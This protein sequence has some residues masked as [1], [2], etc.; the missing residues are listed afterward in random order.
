MTNLCGKGVISQGR[1]I[2]CPTSVRFRLPHPMPPLSA[3]ETNRAR[4]MRSPWSSSV[5][6]PNKSRLGH[7]IAAPMPAEIGVLPGRTTAP[8]RPSQVRKLNSGS[9]PREA[10]DIQPWPT[11]AADL[12]KGNRHPGG[13]G[14]LGV[15]GRGATRMC[16]WTVGRTRLMAHE[17]QPHAHPEIGAGN[18]AAHM[19][20]T[21]GGKVYAAPEHSGLLRA[22]RVGGLVGV[23]DR[24]C[25]H[26]R[27]PQRAYPADDRKPACTNRLPATM[28]AVF[29][30]G[31]SVVEH[32]AVNGGAAGAHPAPG[33]YVVHQARRAV[34][35]W[36]SVRR[37]FTKEA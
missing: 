8:I 17:I 3:A 37:Q 6:A 25:C 27:Q 10:L 1:P 28:R 2:T 12:P 19:S 22:M 11:G 21:S 34:L 20:S 18:H 24:N 35:G 14:P 31:S 9:R 36:A 7:T 32:A 15:P 30:P 33:E 4:A 26:Q 16:R 23:I 13:F 29:F 5:S